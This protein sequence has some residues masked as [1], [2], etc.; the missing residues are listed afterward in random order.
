MPDAKTVRDLADDAALLSV[1][2]QMHLYGVLGEHRWDVDLAAPRLVFT[3]DRGTFTCTRFHL[4]GSAAPG[5]RSWLWG[6]AHP[7][8]DVA[9]AVTAL[10][11]ELRAYGQR[12]GIP[13]L[14][15]AEVPFD[16]LPGSPVDPAD[17]SVV[18]TDAAKAVTGRWSSYS[19]RLHDSGTRLVFLVEHPAFRLPPP[20]A[21]SVANLLELVAGLE[22]A[23]Q[24]HPLRR[25][26]L[27]RGLRASLTPDLTRL[28]ITG[29]D[30]ETAV[31]FDQD[32]RVR[33]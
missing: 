33:P 7:N 25:Y 19:G 6:W 20:T 21:A 27:R 31:D 18:L 17:A 16:D 29:P 4:L 28:T 14:T 12:H 15:A 5:P 22:L 9:G 2:H 23:D 32:N 13:E 1:E 26:A 24:Q 11:T 30:F 8:P 3:G 10:G